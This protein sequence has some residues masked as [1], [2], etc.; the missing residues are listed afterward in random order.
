MKEADRFP[1][2]RVS[3]EEVKKGIADQEHECALACYKRLL[4]SEHSIQS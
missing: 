4:A 3:L 2:A 1:W